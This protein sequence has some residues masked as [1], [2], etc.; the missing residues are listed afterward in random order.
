[1]ANQL[2]YLW[3]SS[4]HQQKF[5]HLLSFSKCTNGIIGLIVNYEYLEDLFH[6]PLPHQAFLESN[7]FEEICNQTLLKNK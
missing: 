4:C 6:L 3:Q 1:M 5:P 2:I 7:Q